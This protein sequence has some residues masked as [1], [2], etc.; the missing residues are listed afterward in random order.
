MKSIIRENVDQGLNR[1]ITDDDLDESLNE[2]DALVHLDPVFVACSRA[3][4]MGRRSPSPPHSVPCPWTP[5]LETPIVPS[6]PTFAT[7]CRSF[8]RSRVIFF[9]GFSSLRASRRDAA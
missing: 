8:G 2:R 9:V 6:R 7:H 3:P 5:W 4:L 1:V